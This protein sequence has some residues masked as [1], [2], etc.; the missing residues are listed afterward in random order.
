MSTTTPTRR[1]ALRLSAASLFA[2]LATA[3]NAST[4]PGQDADLILCGQ[5]VV[6][7]T[8]LAGADAAHASRQESERLFLAT[9]RRPFGDGC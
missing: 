1:G 4:K 8:E 7:E 9:L 6:N 5:F 3:A 2:G